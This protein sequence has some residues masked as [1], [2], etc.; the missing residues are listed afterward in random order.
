MTCDTV[1]GV[2]TYT[3]ELIRALSNHNIHFHLVTAGALLN[4]AQRD[5]VDQLSNVSLYETDYK[6]EWMDN[7]WTDI[8]NSGLHLIELERKIAPDLIHLNSYSYASLPFLAPVLVVAHS[9]VFSWWLSTR[10][11]NPGAEWQEYFNRVKAGLEKAAC[12]VAPS[13]A[14]LGMLSQIYTAPK[15]AFVI[16]NGRNEE[17]F[18]IDKKENTLMCAGRLWDA[19]KNHE[20]LIASANNIRGTIKM[21][22]ETKSEHNVHSNVIFLGRLNEWQMADELASSLIYVSPAKYEPFGLSI[23]EAALSGCALVLG[24]IPSLREIWKDSAFYVNTGDATELANTCNRLL[25]DPSLA[26]EFGQK[27]LQRAKLFSLQ[28]MAGRYATLYDDLL[29]T[30]KE[31][32]T[33]EMV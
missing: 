19:A 8:D 15:K 1:G 6:L 10:K 16:Y 25:D 9:D 28:K 30:R 23:L 3:V 17:R 11:A 12:V 18:R 4:K 26:E 13:H 2:W 32:E 29:M 21:A 24:D 7:P 33:K 20:L 31:I 14:M 27:A 5:Q 22:G